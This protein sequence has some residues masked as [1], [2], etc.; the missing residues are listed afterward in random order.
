MAKGDFLHD[1]IAFW[2]FLMG[3]RRAG[4]LSKRKHKQHKQRI[5]RRHPDFKFEDL[6]TNPIADAVAERYL[7][8]VRRD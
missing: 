1:D 8:S 5:R 4:L 3:A 6:K 2:L 7:E